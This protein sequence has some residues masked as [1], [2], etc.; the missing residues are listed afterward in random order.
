MAGITTGNLITILVLPVIDPNLDSIRL[1]ITIQPNFTLLLFP[2]QGVLHSIFTT[3]IIINI[4]AAGNHSWDSATALHAW[5]EGEV[6][7]IVSMSLEPHI[8]REVYE[9]GNLPPL[10][11]AP[12]VV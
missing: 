11:I 6:G 1:L 8:E 3:R 5:Y 4:R 7:E 10:N 2:L 12:I 9:A